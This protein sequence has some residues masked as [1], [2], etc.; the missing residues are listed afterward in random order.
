MPVRG[1]RAVACGSR[2]VSVILYG[3]AALLSA[4]PA[5]AADVDVPYQPSVVVPRPYSWTGYYFGLYAGGAFGKST[6]E[7]PLPTDSFGISG[8][9][10][11]GTIGFNFELAN[12]VA[13][14]EFDAGWANI[15]GSTTNNCLPSEC[16]T[17]SSGLIT[18]RGRLGPAL[19]RFLPFLTG[20]IAFGDVN[21]TVTAIGTGSA[22][23]TGVALGAGAEFA[24]DYNWTAKLEYLHVDLGTYSCGPCGVIAPDRVSFKMNVARA[25]L[26]YKFDW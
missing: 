26:N 9:L 4:A 19:G 11:G 10:V 8:A 3:L 13:G 12:W 7:A 24:L 6:H 15:K 21:P 25:G 16:R 17:E 14:I 22:Y 5:Q 23:M 1:V 18:L 20:G 2:L